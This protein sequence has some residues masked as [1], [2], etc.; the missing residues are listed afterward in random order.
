[1]TRW[2]TF[3]LRS[4]GREVRPQPPTGNGDVPRLRP[5]ET[6]TG[7]VKP[8]RA[9][10]RLARP[11]PLAGIAL[12]LVALVGY[13]SV[14]SATTSRTLVLV[15]TRNLPAGAVLGAGDI[16][17]AELAGDGTVMDSVVAERRAGRVVGRRLA[18]PV[19]AGVPL[20]RAA[21]SAPARSASAFTLAVPAVRAVGGSV[22]PGDRVTVLATFGA[23]SGAARTRVVARGLEVLASGSDGGSLERDGATIPVT[24]ALPD[25][26]GVSELAL[27]N[28]DATISLLL[29]GERGATDPIPPAGLD[30]EP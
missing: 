29:D 25:P 2:P 28:D 27:A 16:R 13:W 12:V 26:S 22:Q 3:K 6:S 14:Y 15:P 19:S 24:V 30:A 8:A 10:R 17:T 9:A 20:P 11:V 7:S 4:G 18:A 5:R 1:V 21:L 23:G